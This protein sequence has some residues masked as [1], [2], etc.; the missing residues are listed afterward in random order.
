MK[1]GR[2]VIAL[3]QTDAPSTS[4]ASRAF[5]VNRRCAFPSAHGEIVGDL[6]VRLERRAGDIT[7]RKARS[8]PLLPAVKAFPQT[9]QGS[10]P[11]EPSTETDS[12]NR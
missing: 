9:L 11:G 6:G 5:R 3:G 10:S 8:L 2:I 4:A 12:A 1:S 7:K